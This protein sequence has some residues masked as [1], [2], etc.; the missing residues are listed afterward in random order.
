MTELEI[1][2]KHIDLGFP[3]MRVWACGFLSIHVS[4]QPQ[5]LSVEIFWPNKTR[6][7]HGGQTHFSRRHSTFFPWSRALSPSVTISSSSFA[8]VRFAPLFPSSSLPL[9]AL[10]GAA[11]HYTHGTRHLCLSACLLVLSGN[12]DKMLPQVFTSFLKTGPQK[13]QCWYIHK[14]VNL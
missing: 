13:N 2:R 6:H 1:N 9:L 12:T 5:R 10:Y 11:R 4:E 3:S 7:Q 8:P 14:H